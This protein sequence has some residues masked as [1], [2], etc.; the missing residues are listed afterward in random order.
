[1][2][3]KAM[4][5]TLAFLM[6]LISVIYAVWFRSVSASTKSTSPFAERYLSPAGASFLNFSK[7]I[8]GSGNLDI[9][10]G[11]PIKF[12][13]KDFL[14]DTHFDNPDTE[15]SADE[16]IATIHS[17]D[18]GNKF[19]KYKEGNELKK[20]RKCEQ[21]VHE[22]AYEMMCGK[23]GTYILNEDIRNIHN[24][25]DF[26]MST[27]IYC[28]YSNYSNDHA[29][30][31]EKLKI[32]SKELNINSCFVDVKNHNFNINIGLVSL[33]IALHIAKN[34]EKLFSN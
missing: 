18:T 23:N 14:S 10:E 2:R 25:Y 32:I 34:K 27:I 31:S 3:I 17:I 19:S 16:I 13:L 7:V 33:K 4:A 9:D 28:S 22:S 15:T 8:S 1:M 20:A 30:H 21:I 24:E 26:Y 11:Q 5:A 29:E 12:R 6:V